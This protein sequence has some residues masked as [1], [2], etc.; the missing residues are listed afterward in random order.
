MPE[1]NI[2]VRVRLKGADTFQRGMNQMQQSMGWL[3][4]TKGIL[5]SQVIQRGLQ[6]VMQ[7]INQ[8]IDASVKYE[9]ALAS[10]QKTAGLSDT[11]LANM[12]EKIMDLSER[13]PVTSTEIARLADTVAHLGLSEDQILPFTEVMIA[14]GEATDMTAEEAA[15]ALAQLANVMHTTTDDYERLGSTI[16]ELG[17][18]SATTESAIVDMA[19]NMAGS[20]SLVG[21]SEADVLAYAAALSSI[22]VEAASG[23]TS[24]QKMA[25]RFELMT[26]SG[27]EELARFAEV[28]GMTAA[29]FTDAWNADPAATLAAFIDG[30]GHLNESGGSAVG[31]LSE[32][33]ITEVR[34]T[35]NIAGL[36]AAGDL[37]DRSLNNSRK[38]WEDNTALAEATGIAYS[39]TASRLQM[40]KN[41]IENAQIA[42]GDGLKDTK[43]ELKEL[44]A[45]GARGLR[46]LIMDNSLPKQIDELNAKYDQVG[47][48]LSNARD[49]AQSL[50]ASLAALGDPAALD[51]AGLESYEAIMGALMQIMPGIGDLYDETTHQIQGG[52][53]ALAQ[54]V[55]QQYEVANSANELKRSGEAVEAYNAKV[56]KLTELRQQEALAYAEL[57]AAEAEYDK[58]L[59]THDANEAMTSEELA[60][61]DAAS[62]AYSEV[63]GAVKE[64]SEYLDEYSY[65][66]D[67]AETA[68]DNLAAAM[69]AA[70]GAATAEASGIQKMQDSLTLYSQ[71]AQQILDDYNAALEE[72]QKNADRVFS[73][74]FGYKEPLDDLKIKSPDFVLGAWESQIEYAENYVKNLEKVKELGLSDALVEQLSDGSMNSAAVLQGIVDDNGKSIDELNAK[75]ESVQVA[76]DTMAAAMADASSQA[77]TRMAEVQAAMDGMVS[78]ADQSATAE[79]NA[80]STVQGLISGIDS[81]I[82]TLQTKVSLVNQLMNSLSGGGG[83][84]GSHAAGLSYVPFDGYLAQLHRGEMVL[85][86]LE[87]RAYRAEQFANYDMV[88]RIQQM[89]NVN[90]NQRTER[91]VTN[92]FRF[93]EVTVR[94]ESD[95]DHLSRELYALT[96]R[97]QRMKGA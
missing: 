39:T 56:E 18:T 52:T 28:S 91:N 70:E 61:L 25:T 83:G 40:A 26:A 24:V 58:Y 27:S 60:R 84:D 30:L 59:S 57:Q 80:A 32:L 49:Q 63:S 13:V 64:C 44:E 10:L 47:K 88:P 38:A 76:K 66:I 4:V 48:S 68:T 1:R 51:S 97:E 86:A 37:L 12:S 78:A 9:S 29:E 42:V 5:G 31:V 67:D 95:I 2:D 17:R 94:K 3:D 96:R 45:A 82:S 46:N 65:I 87:A 33:G 35:R 55:E 54:Y 62:A 85:T 15:T 36:A 71:E 74:T 90:N 79:G 81:K 23:A 34:L 7:A 53:D 20:A 6:E 8:S 14:L 21:M 89:S 16:F 50:V 69:S 43:L 22:G 41:A 77:T 19:H 93:G 11:A 73:D 75:Y 72:A 92:N